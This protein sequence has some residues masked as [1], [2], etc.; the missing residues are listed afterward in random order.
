M[1]F[2]IAY[3]VLLGL[4]AWWV[5]K[6][7]PKTTAKTANKPQEEAQETIK[8]TKKQVSSADPEQMREA[9]KKRQKTLEELI[10]KKSGNTVRL[11]EIEKE[12]E[13]LQKQLAKSLQDFESLKEVI[14]QQ[15][16]EILEISEQEIIVD[17]VEGDEMEK[18]A[19]WEEFH[20]LGEEE[21]I[22]D[23]IL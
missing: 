12:N 10:S 15:R 9:F 3:F 19:V 11:S 22:E 21:E 13:E 1:G 8:T 6:S 5:L 2:F 7:K 16:K 23:L 14:E 4:A 17:E 20:N 18:N